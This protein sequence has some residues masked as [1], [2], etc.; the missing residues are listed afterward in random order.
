MEEPAV[1]SR[2]GAGSA[3][4]TSEAAG[5]AA[6]IDW[7]RVAVFDLDGLLV[8]SEPLWHRAEI[9]VF[10][11]YG[12]PLTVELCRTT[13]GWFVADVA[14]HWL[15]QFALSG[16]SGPDPAVVAD[17]VV[18]RM[19]DL[20]GAEVDLKPGALAVLDACADR[21]LRLALASSSSHRL[22]DAALGRHGLARRFEAICSA[23]DV[24][25]GKPDPAVFLAAAR[26]MQE[27]PER[28][29]VLEDSA[30]GVQ[31]ALAAGMACVQV[32]EH[33][34]AGGGDS[35]DADAVLSSLTA[36]DGSIDDVARAF[37]ARRVPGVPRSGR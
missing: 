33:R 14:R 8:D 30:V 1:T 7:F 36:F 2:S 21:G 26:A 19:E 28:C 18:D 25:A 12:M 35:S 5:D 6:R 16:R 15:D 20:L 29:V 27:P 13:K 17:E 23:E 34:G 24:G 11:R 31:A 22:I 32:P 37:L 9:E 3:A 4:A 10:G